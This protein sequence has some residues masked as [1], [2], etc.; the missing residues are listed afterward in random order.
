LSAEETIAY[1]HQN[2]GVCI[3]AHPFRDNNR[4]LEKAIQTL[5]LDAIEV[6]NGR[7][8]DENNLKALTIAKNK[9]IPMIGGSDSHT[10]GEI[11]KFVTRF[12]TTIRDEQDF[13][14]AI[15]D[16]AFHPVVK[17]NYS[18]KQFNVIKVV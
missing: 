17:Q 7:T 4:G 1:V 11:G 8:K 9:K 14:K 18:K 5:D 12:K 3:A 15:K 13:I 6:F 16:R 10:P 2:G